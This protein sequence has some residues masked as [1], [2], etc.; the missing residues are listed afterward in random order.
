MAICLGIY[1]IFRQSHVP[2]HQPDQ[3]R[4]SNRRP[5]LN[6]DTIATGLGREPSGTQ[7]GLVP[8]DVETAGFLLQKGCE[9]ASRSSCWDWNAWFIMLFYSVQQHLIRSAST[10]TSDLGESNRPNRHRKIAF[11]SP[12]QCHLRRSKNT[13]TL[14]LKPRRP[15]SKKWPVQHGKP[16]WILCPARCG[17][18]IFVLFGSLLGKIGACF[19]TLRY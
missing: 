10:L 17:C 6:S 15:A 14:Q 4:C 3:I 18:P 7:Q 16:G 12:P 11:V 19:Q 13:R 8:K 9:N 5:C 1:P 2:N